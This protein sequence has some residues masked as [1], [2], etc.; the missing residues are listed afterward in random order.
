[1]VE[2][3]VARSATF[4]IWIDGRLR[5]CFPAVDPD[6]FRPRFEGLVIQHLEEFD[7]PHMIEIEFLDDP[8]PLTRFFRFGTDARMMRKPIAVDF[9]E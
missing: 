9:R 5:W 4:R 6:K 8:D 1:M 3:L 2:I 7:A